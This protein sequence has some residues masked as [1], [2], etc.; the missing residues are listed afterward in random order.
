MP[1]L[2]GNSRLQRR[3]VS[4]CWAAAFLLTWTAT[5]AES[6]RT[7]QASI[8]LHVCARPTPESEPKTTP[9]RRRGCRSS[10]PA[11][12]WRSDGTA[13]RSRQSCSSSSCGSSGRQISVEE[14][15][16]WGPAWSWVCLSFPVL[17]LLPEQM[18]IPVLPAVAGDVHDTSYLS[19][20]NIPFKQ[21]QWKAPDEPN[22]FA[23]EGREAS[24]YMQFI[25]DFYECLPE[26]RLLWK[27]YCLI[28]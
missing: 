6:F 19:N 16:H 5:H 15:T 2:I 1:K 23:P 14:R 11:N 24:A 3:L 27:S 20:A 25:A 4:T 10:W 21:Y 17:G 8:I 7:A 9:P 13:S 12:R 26:A 22:Y 28:Y 18:K